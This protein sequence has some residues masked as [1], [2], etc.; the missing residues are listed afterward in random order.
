M[1]ITA[2]AHT[3][4]FRTDITAKQELW[5]VF[6]VEFHASVLV[7]WNAF[8]RILIQEFISSIHARAFRLEA[9]SHLS[10]MTIIV[11]DFESYEQLAIPLH[12]S[13]DIANR[14]LTTEYINFFL[15][16]VVVL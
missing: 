3:I 6:L 11:L 13:S 2:R 1:R 16:A 10:S 5:I 7:A 8:I 14:N 9:N 12:E 4:D 15:R